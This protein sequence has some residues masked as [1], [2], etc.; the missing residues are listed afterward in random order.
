MYVCCLIKNQIILHVVASFTSI[1]P[2]SVAAGVSVTLS[3]TRHSEPGAVTPSQI[4]VTRCYRSGSEMT[5]AEI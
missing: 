2:E 4:D 3:L 5:S 1:G